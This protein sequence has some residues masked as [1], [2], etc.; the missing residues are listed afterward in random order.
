MVLRTFKDIKFFKNK[1][2]NEWEVYIRQFSSCQAQPQQTPA[3]SVTLCVI[4]QLVSSVNWSEREPLSTF[5][6]LRVPRTTKITDSS[7]A[8]Y[9]T[10]MTTGVISQLATYRH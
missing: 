5:K 6:V 3:R 10:S 9:D 8:E 7:Q 2:N 1:F 4:S